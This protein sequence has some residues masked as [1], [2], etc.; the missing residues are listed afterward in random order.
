MPRLLS[1]ILLKTVART[2]LTLLYRVEVRG[3]ENFRLTG[4]HHVIVA[5]HQSFLDAAVI[6]VFM[7]SDPVFAVNT[8]IAKRWWARPALALV[9]TFSIDPTNSMSLKSLIREVEKGRPLVIFPEGRITVTG[10]LMKVYDGPGLVVDKARAEVVP[11]RLAGLQHTPF[12]R[13]KGRVTRRLFPKVTMT[14]LPPRSLVIDPQVKGRERRKA[15]GRQLYDLMSETLFST[16]DTDKTL[17]RSL[18]EASA[19]HGRSRAIVED[20]EFQPLTYGRLVAGAF[21]LGRKLKLLT[22]E[23]EAVGLLLPNSVG[24]LVAFFALQATARVPA[25]LNVS[26]GAAGMLAACR[27]ANV[28]IVLCARRFV[29]RGKLHTVLAEMERHTRVVYLDDLRA[30][31]G[32]FDKA[33][34]LAKSYA[35]PL[36]YRDRSPDSPAVILFTSGSE[37]SP[38]G[39]VLS[40][41]NIQ[42]NRH[43]VGA[44]I[45]FNAQDKVFN[46]LPMFHAFGLTVG[47]LLPVLAGVKTF[48]YPSPLHYRIVPE[49]VYG[50]DS[51]VLFGTDTFLR[52]YARMANPYDFYSVRL[53]GAGAEKVSEETRRL[54]NDLFGIRILEGYG[55]TETAPVITFNTPMYFKAGTVGRLMPGV[56]YRLEA[57]PGVADGGRLHV[58]GPNVMLGYMRDSNPG[59]IDR[60]AAADGWY[61]TG[62]IV[63]LDSDGFV[64]IQGRAKRFAKIGGEMVSLG[65]VEEFAAQVSFSHK[66]AAVTRPD[67]RR[68]EQ[69][70]LVTEDPLLTRSRFVDAGSARG[71]PPI[72]LPAEVIY[73]ERLPVLGTG[74]TDHPGLERA[75]RERGMSESGM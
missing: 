7:P 68:G 37:G 57:V 22:R 45:A 27:T 1:R 33:L 30:E 46:P 17:F 20:I 62:D 11:V 53:V 21:V 6:A 75:I 40:H 63:A 38:K 69:V 73:V 3:A 54:W 74:K 31:I 52:G 4:K 71:V 19:L 15:A 65:A 55:A 13:L 50:T 26:A 34:G 43:Q 5:N 29:E 42:A 32:G 16:T 12:S 44:R 10:S 56:E 18:L 39:V 41:R 60:G 64:R 9:D 66:H 49:L 67:P 72:M 51:T 23:G 48:L 59:V 70:V 2:V 8:Q 14:V 36:A 35:P 24:A 58:K 28:R 61:D 47:T 25:M